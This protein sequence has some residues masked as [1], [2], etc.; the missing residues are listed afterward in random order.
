MTMVHPATARVADPDLP[1]VATLLSE[2]VPGPIRAIVEAA[3]GSVVDSTPIQVTW[4]PGSSISVRYRTTIEGGPMAG[5]QQL[6]AVSG[7]IPDGAAVVGAG[8]EE[9]GVWRVPFDPALPGLPAALDNESARQLLTSL[10]AVDGPVR[11]Q[12][13]AYRPGRRAVVAVEGPAEGIYLKLVR[14]KKVE[15][16]HRDHKSFPDDLP[17]PRSLGYSREMGVMA[18]QAMPGSTLRDVLEDPTGIAPGPVALTDLLLTLPAPSVDRVQPSIIER[19]PATADMIRRIVP[20]RADT[21]DEFVEQLGEEDVDELAPVHG[22]FYEAQILVEN[23]AVV[24]LI[25]IDTYGM[26]RRGDDPGV[27]LGHLALWQTMSSQPAR[28]RHYAQSLLT[29]WDRMYD[30]V[31]IRRR[32]AA[33]LFTLATGSCR[34]QA[35]D[36]PGETVQ[37]LA[38]AHRWLESARRVDRS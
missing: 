9:V 29:M 8:G 31:D 13:K 20:D 3:D 11:T 37:R 17:V 36:W 18:L 24:G 12:L 10:G 33:T 34:V 1:A 22:D 21:V 27:M 6:V 19:V 28:V 16:L 32:A 30:P 35:A 4:W 25:D 38:L 5:V 2:P 7:R 23:G 26:G 14:P 15:Q